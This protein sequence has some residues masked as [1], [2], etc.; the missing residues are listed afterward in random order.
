MYVEIISV[1]E[2]ESFLRL[3]LL[4][5]WR[6]LHS[7]GAEFPGRAGDLSAMRRDSRKALTDVQKVKP[8]AVPSLSY[9]SA[10]I[11]LEGLFKLPSSVV[12]K[13]LCYKLEG[14]GLDIRLGDF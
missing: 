3:L 14:R 5:S 12:V 6:E 9:L 11:Y 13:A 8:S 1:I 4:S 2:F 7:E 10:D